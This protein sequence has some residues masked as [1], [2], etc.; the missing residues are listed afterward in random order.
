MRDLSRIQFVI[1]IP[2]LVNW[3]LSNN[4]VTQKAL[5]GRCRPMVYKYVYALF[6]DAFNS[7]LLRGIHK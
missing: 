1:H 5:L 7:S 2:E 3:G 4:E 6:L